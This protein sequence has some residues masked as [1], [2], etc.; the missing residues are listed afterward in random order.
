MNDDLMTRYNYDEFIDHK[1]ERWMQFEA[2][3]KIGQP[4]PD[5]PLTSLEGETVQLAS[6]WRESA[7]TIVEFG[8]FT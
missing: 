6:L 1:F 4:A 7:Y 2:S 5:F 8:S 3:P